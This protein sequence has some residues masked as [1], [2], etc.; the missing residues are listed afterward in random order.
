MRLYT[1]VDTRLMFED[2]FHNLAAFAATP[3]AR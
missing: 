2:V 3:S 1:C